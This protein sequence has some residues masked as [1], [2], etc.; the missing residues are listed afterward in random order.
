MDNSNKLKG[1]WATIQEKFNIIKA[2]MDVDCC[3]A[4]PCVDYNYIDNSIQYLNQRIDNL[5]Q[6]LSNHIDNGHLPPIEG[7]EK[8]KKA[9]QVLGIDK[10]YQI[11]PTIIY[12][13][14]GMPEKIVAVISH[15]SPP[16]DYPKTKTEYADP[17]NYK[18]PVDSKSRVRAA[19]SYINMPKNQK[20]YTSSEISAIKSRIKRAGKKYGIDFSE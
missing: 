7:A 14:D 10:D 4:I 19:W 8:M 18:Y 13:E 16:K 6:A 3:D 2:Y 15:K 1:D 9:L 5:F 11:Q 12:A 17:K 20:G